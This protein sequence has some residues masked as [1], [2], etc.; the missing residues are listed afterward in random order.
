MENF[1]HVQY[2]DKYADFRKEHLSKNIDDDFKNRMNVLA[3]KY[4]NDLWLMSEKKFG[5]VGNKPQI[6]LCWNENMVGSIAWGHGVRIGMV[7]A[8]MPF[9]VLEYKSINNKP[10]IGYLNTWSSEAHL[11]CTIAHELAHTVHKRLC[12]KNPALCKKP[13]GNGWRMVYRFFRTEYVNKTA[14]QATGETQ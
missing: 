7:R 6:K 9:P 10:E 13:H 12:R 3:E 1:T 14:L 8:T 5:Q 4:F 2:W 11:V